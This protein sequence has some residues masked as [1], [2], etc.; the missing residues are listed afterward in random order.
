MSD[1]LKRRSIPVLNAVI[2]LAF[3]FALGAIFTMIAG[4]NPLTV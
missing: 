1:N 3:A 2:P 4:Y